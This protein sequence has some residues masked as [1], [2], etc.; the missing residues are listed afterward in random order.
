MPSGTTRTITAKK[1]ILYSFM[2]KGV[3]IIVQLLLVPLTLNYLS[4]ELY[5]VWITLSSIILWIGFFDIGI[6][7]GLKN[8]LAEA[9]ACSDFTL[10]KQLVSTSY[11]T[12]TAIFIPLC[13]IGELLIPHVKWCQI[14]NISAQYSTDITKVIQVIFACVCMQMIFNAISSVL[15]AYQKVALSS[16]FLPIGNLISLIVI[17]ILTKCTEPSL[18]NLVLSI[19]YIPLIVL[20]FGNIICYKKHMKEV[21]PSIASVKIKLIK[22]L[23]SI[24]LGFFFLSLQYILIFQ[25]TNFLIS[26]TSSPI[27]VTQYNIA[28]RYLSI[29]LMIFGI[30]LSPF[31]P[32]FTDAYV[33]RDFVW[34]RQVYEKLIKLYFIGVIGLIIMVI[35]APIIFKIWIGNEIKI[36][37]T[38]TISVAFFLIIYN[39]STLQSNLLNGIGVIRVQVIISII[40]LTIFAPLAL[41]L[42]HKYHAIGI[43]NAMTFVAATYSIVNTLALRK[44]LYS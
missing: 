24:G 23:F 12:L 19:S 20:I 2:I 13:I 25:S 43:V 7:L 31:W 34:M 5:G 35:I 26:Y 38:M 36:P 11:A 41:T 18:M 39:W 37:V 17:Y 8:R 40:G 42:G 32:A 33:K 10:G 6:T 14:L 1:N 30:I 3:S 29:T 4:D 9:I 27:Y 15:S 28:Y 21:R 44:V 16:I 22:K